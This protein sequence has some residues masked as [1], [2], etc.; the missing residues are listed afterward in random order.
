MMLREFALASAATLALAACGQSADSQSA[1]EVAANETASAQQDADAAEFEA[2]SGAYE[3]DYKHR[4]ITFS[5]FHQGYSNPW[6]RW[7]DWTGT[8]NWDAEAPENSSVNITIDTTSI[9]SGVE[10][11]DG[12]LNGERFFDTANY[13]EITFVSTSVEKTG[14]NTGKVT[15]DLTMKGVTKPVTLE[16]VFHKGAY[17]ERGNKYKLGF[18]GKAKLLRSEFDLGFLVPIVSD[19]V[20]VVIETEW[21]MPAPA[22]E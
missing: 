18:S 4:Y 7:N 9:D 11:F 12:H 20:N 15:G 19:E 21:E 5:Y 16:V 22:S 2:I 17:D 13:P 1:S 8:L 6:L 14:A 3:P 10:E